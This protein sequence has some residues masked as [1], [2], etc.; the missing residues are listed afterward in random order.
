MLV[1]RQMTRGSWQAW[2]EGHRNEGRG[3]DNIN[4]DISNTLQY[5][6]SAPMFSKNKKGF[7]YQSWC[8]S[9]AEFR[10]RQ[11]AT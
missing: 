1:A 4:K 5:S 10:V 11:M 3:I 7:F 8:K 2:A 9:V 6:L